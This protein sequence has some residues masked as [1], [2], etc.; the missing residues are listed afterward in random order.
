MEEDTF[1]DVPLLLT[2]VSSQDLT[3]MILGPIQFDDPVKRENEKHRVLISRQAYFPDWYPPYAMVSILLLVV[4]RFLAFCLLPFFIILVYMHHNHHQHHHYCHHQLH[5]YHHPL[6][7]YV[8]LI[9]IRFLTFYLI[10]FLLS[11]NICIVIIITIINIT[12]AVTTIIVA[13]IT[14][15]IATTR[16]FLQTCHIQLHPTVISVINML[17]NIYARY[18]QAS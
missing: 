17:M 7:S 4:I 16:V 10:P 8:F 18:C 12:I 3:N 11:F 14:I 13:I 5:P 1:V 9:I 6:T 2:L 15:A